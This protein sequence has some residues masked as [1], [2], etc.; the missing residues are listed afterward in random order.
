MNF[1]QFSQPSSLILEMA[2]TASLLSSQLLQ[3]H[4]MLSNNSTPKNRINFLTPNSS[5]YDSAKASCENLNELS[6]IKEINEKNSSFIN[7]SLSDLEST[8]LTNATLSDVSI[9]ENEVSSLRKCLFQE[10]SQ[11]E[12]SI[13]SNSSILK[14]TPFKTDPPEIPRIKKVHRDICKRPKSRDFFQSYQ[15]SKIY[16]QLSFS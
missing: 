14:H 3:L 6:F 10:N 2:K 7:S 15:K 8:Y 12:T 11:S 4:K 16:K 9:C 5:G 1:E 13:R